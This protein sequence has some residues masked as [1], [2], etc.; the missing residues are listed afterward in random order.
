[1]QCFVET[2]EHVFFHHKTEI[3]TTRSKW[4]VGFVLDLQTYRRH[5]DSVTGNLKTIYKKVKIREVPH[6][7][8]HDTDL[9]LSLLEL[10]RY[11][12]TLHEF[13]INSFEDA[14]H[15]GKS[16]KL[17]RN[18]RNVRKK[19]QLSIIGVALSG[20]FSG[21]SF[22]ETLLLK[23]E[24]N[25][26]CANQET[27]RHVVKK[28]LSIINITRIEVQENR[29]AINQLMKITTALGAQVQKD[30]FF[31]YLCRDYYIYILK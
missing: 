11:M 24:A 13:N 4:L 31:C 10:V 19:R 8:K 20:L 18:K 15:L 5:I 22:V 27:I 6:I 17:T 2:V 30:D 21:M 23:N 14:T 9:V 7:D 26:L 1:M 28:S 29:N 25:E 12:R 16:F 3:Y